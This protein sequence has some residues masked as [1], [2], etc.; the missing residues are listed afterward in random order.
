MHTY[1]CMM[2]FELV[3]AASVADPRFRSR[4]DEAFNTA[5]TDQSI[6]RRIR[7]K[8]SFWGAHFFWCFLFFGLV[9]FDAKSFCSSFLLYFFW[10]SFVSSFYFSVFVYLCII[11]MQTVVVALSTQ[12][13]QPWNNNN[14]NNGNNSR[15]SNSSTHNDSN[16]GNNSSSTNTNNSSNY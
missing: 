3:E 1:I 11:L 16:N 2:G 4:Q 6:R 13:L 15:H 12:R 5:E 8:S 9:V 10:L 7:I 14:S